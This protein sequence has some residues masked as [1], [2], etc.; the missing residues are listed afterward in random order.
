MTRWR[1]NLVAFKCTATAQRT[2]DLWQMRELMQARLRYRYWAFSKYLK[3]IKCKT[4]KES[5]NKSASKHRA[6]V[7]SVRACVD[8][9]HHA[10][11]CVSCLHVNLA[12]FDAFS[13]FVLRACHWLFR[14]ASLSG[15]IATAV[16]VITTFQWMRMI[17]TQ[18]QV[19]Q[20]AEL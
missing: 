11:Q 4:T 16:F 1:D 13:M 19:E 7:W 6:S 14:A 2:H 9:N 17:F 8:V 18:I 12:M 10:K 20:F 5:A 3:T 15:T